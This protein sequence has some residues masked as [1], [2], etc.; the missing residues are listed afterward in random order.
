MATKPTSIKLQIKTIALD[1]LKNHPD[2]M[3]YSELMRAIAERNPALERNTIHGTIWDL[4]REATEIRRPTPGSY[5]LTKFQ[6]EEVDESP[7]KDSS[8]LT[9]RERKKEHEYYKSFAEWL[10][11]K[12]I[13]TRAIVLGG[14]K[15]GPKWGTPDV[16]GRRD[17]EADAIIK[18]E[19]EIISAEIKS[20]S[21]DLM[22]AFGQAC[23]Y[24][25]FSHQTY[26]V[27][28]KTSKDRGVE[29]LEGLCQ[30]FGIGLV[31]FDDKAPK[32]EPAIYEVR[33]LPMRRRPDLFWTNRYLP[34]IK[35][36]LF[37]T[38]TR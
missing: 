8:E 27:I 22:T 3:K 4:Q 9:P 13:C 23:A 36:E 7:G 19:T 12:G 21:E 11:G 31:L 25:L 29:R 16:I 28:P 6:D 1:I 14:N 35:N 15:F 24:H 5:Q 37:G 26:L 38:G 18:A 33:N 30:V 17:S 20:N 34:K 10:E 32:I 2:G